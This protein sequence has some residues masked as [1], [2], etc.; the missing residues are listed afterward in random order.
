MLKKVVLP[1][2]VMSATTF[3]TA[4]T[5]ADVD[6]AL[7]NI[8]AIVKADD[9]S[10]LRRKI[11]KVQSYYRLKL[12]DY[13][14]GVTCDGD[15]L[16]RTAVKAN[17]VKTGTLLVKKMPKSQLNKPESDGKTL[18]NW[19][20]EQGFTSSPITNILQQRI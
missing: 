20:D 18:L 4:K 15:S 14:D 12:Q 6:T 7:L 8:C 17:A 19:I 11:N 1:M 5:Y 13:Y 2:I 10:E 16:I 9:K 3:T